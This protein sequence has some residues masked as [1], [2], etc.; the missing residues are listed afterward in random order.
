MSSRAAAVAEHEMMMI[1]ISEIL[2]LRSAQSHAERFLTSSQWF[3]VVRQP[4]ALQRG[5]E[6]RD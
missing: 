3:G 5:M 2:R 1:I 4:S 6:Q